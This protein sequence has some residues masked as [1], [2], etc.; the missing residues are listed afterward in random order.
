[1]NHAKHVIPMSDTSVSIKPEDIQPTVLPD[2]FIQSD[3]V[4]KLNA[5]SLPRYDQLPN[6]TLYRDQV[7]EYIDLWMEPLSIC[8]EQSVITPSMINN[9]VK[10]GLVPAP[11]KK[12]YGRGVRTIS[13]TAPRRIQASCGTPSG[14]ATRGTS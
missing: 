9:Y 2:A 6:V 10:V 13:W 11:V 5:L 1:M 3:M 8:V 12:Q 7:I 14:S 4:G